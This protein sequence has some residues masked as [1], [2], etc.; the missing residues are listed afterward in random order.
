MYHQPPRGGAGRKSLRPSLEL[1]ERRRRELEESGTQW[2]PSGNAYRA[3]ALCVLG[4]LCIS[5]AVGV[6][7]SA[8]TNFIATADPAYAAGL[9]H[10]APV[11][12]KAVDRKA[13]SHHVAHFD[14]RSSHRRSTHSRAISRG[15]LAQR[16]PDAAPL[17]SPAPMTT[18]APVAEPT[19]LSA[20]PWT[21]TA[22]GTWTTVAS[23]AV[24]AGVDPKK[25]DLAFSSDDAD[26]KALK[27][28]LICPPRHSSNKIRPELD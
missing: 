1:V 4:S 18:S 22:D 5:A 25:I 9:P 26:E 24:P 28:C 12:H 23:L 11:E 8:D 2:W 16:D 13:A 27:N 7:M 20:H 14:V 6:G 17:S 3:A 21:L 19:M 10:A 15:V